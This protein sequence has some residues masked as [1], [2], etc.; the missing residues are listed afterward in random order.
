[1][2]HDLHTRICI[3]PE[4]AAVPGRPVT[5]TARAQWAGVLLADEPAA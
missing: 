2:Q 1:M 4:K 5:L 3:E